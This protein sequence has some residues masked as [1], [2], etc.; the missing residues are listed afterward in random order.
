MQGFK[1]ANCVP[2]GESAGRAWPRVCY[3][4][5]WCLVLGGDSWQWCEGSGK[6]AEAGNT[7]CINQKLV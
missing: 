1:R 2:S 7:A 4:L 3:A 5:L 6:P